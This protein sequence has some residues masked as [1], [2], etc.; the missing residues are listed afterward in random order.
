[1]LERLPDDRYQPA[2]NV[3]VRVE[4]DHA[5]ALLA[6]EAGLHIRLAPKPDLDRA[7]ITALRVRYANVQ[8]AELYAK[9]MAE[10]QKA[11]ADDDDICG[12]HDNP[13]V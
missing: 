13:S 3:L 1:M 2:R 5:G 7:F 6:L 10:V 8:E 4:G 11:H 12:V 9:A